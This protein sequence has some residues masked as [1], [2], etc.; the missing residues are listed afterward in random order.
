[1]P[2]VTGPQAAKMLGRSL[3]TVHRRIDDGSLPARQ[4]GT[5]ERKRVYIDLDELRR[6]AEK[7]GYR[8]DETKAAQYTK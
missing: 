5:G 6:F 4:E 7:Y 3:Q 8:L 2:E 1:M